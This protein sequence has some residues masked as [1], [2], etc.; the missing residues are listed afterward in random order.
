MANRVGVH[1][2]ID[3]V[4]GETA[5][6]MPMPPAGPRGKTYGGVE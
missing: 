2:D 6:V 3:V 4:D 5:R 1:V